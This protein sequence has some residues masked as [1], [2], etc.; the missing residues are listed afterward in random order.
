MS[1]VFI[2]GTRR[3]ELSPCNTTVDVEGTVLRQE[4]LPL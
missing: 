3:L 2:G 4:Q 1:L